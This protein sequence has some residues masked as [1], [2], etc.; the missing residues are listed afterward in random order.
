MQKED[1]EKAISSGILRILVGGL[2][3]YYAYALA[4]DLGGSWETKQIV[5]LIFAILFLVVGVF[6]AIA[7]I[8]GF[9][10]M[11]KRGILFSDAQEETIDQEK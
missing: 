2:L 9:I 7:G 6:F 5:L 11:Y 4:T 8:V 10:K 1:R 3:V